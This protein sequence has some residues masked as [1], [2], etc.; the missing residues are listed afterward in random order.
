MDFDPLSLFTPPE[1][2]ERS[3]LSGPES[4]EN[5]EETGPT[6]HSP[7]TGT[8]KYPAQEHGEF[9]HPDPET[10]LEPVHS[11]DLPLLQLKPPALVLLTVLKLLSPN[12]IYNFADDEKTF[13][14]IEEI[15]GEKEVQDTV[16]E[17]LVWLSA[18]CGRFDTALKL[19]HLPLLSTSLKRTHESAYNA[20][21]TSIVS[22]PLDWVDKEDDKDA[23]SKLASLRLSE[24]C[25][26]TA[27]PEITRKI[28][29]PNLSQF[30]TRGKYI[31]LKEPS[32]TSDNLGLKTWGS[33]IILASKLVQNHLFSPEKHL[34]SPVLELGSGTGLVGLVGAL[35]G[36]EVTL[37]DLPEIVPNLKTNLDLNGVVAGADQLDWS[38]PS[39]FLEKYGKDK[40]FNT[41][42][43]SDPIY[44]SQHPYWVVNMIE[45]FLSQDPNARVLIQLPIRKSYEK[46][47]EVL[48]DLLEEQRLEPTLTETE[49]GDDEFGLTQ[50]S[51]SR[52][53]RK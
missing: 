40:K 53:R 5:T 50:Y 38:C 47:R 31:L 21:L 30:L 36:Y 6:S 29:L 11:H 23:V 3:F 49:V 18:H 35:L 1:R 44:S 42:I 34:L 26:R 8:Q 15:F 41:V 45:M 46:E 28:T 20:W 7:N 17:A 43:L 27:Q 51:F 25:G 10:H 37:T 19:A 12:D 9:E 24:N 22:S 33:S 14:G 52:Y 48:R 13:D 32:L 39:L 2:T 16:K 4:P